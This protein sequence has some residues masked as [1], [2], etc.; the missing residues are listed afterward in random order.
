MIDSESLQI[1]AIL[2]VIVIAAL[3]IFSHLGKKL[4][5]AEKYIESRAKEKEN[6]SEN[7]K[8]YTI[9]L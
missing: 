7:E 2:I 5:E 9:A 1:I 3:L 8:E 4:N 6:E